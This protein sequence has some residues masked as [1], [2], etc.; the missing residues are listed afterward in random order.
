MSTLVIRRWHNAFAGFL[1]APMEINRIQSFATR[2]YLTCLVVLAYSARFGM[3]NTAP[4]WFE[5]LPELNWLPHETWIVRL[6]YTLT[7]LLLLAAAFVPRQSL[8]I[9][10]FFSWFMAVGASYGSG[11]INHLEASATIALGIMALGPTDMAWPIRFTGLYWILIIFLSGLNKLFLSGPL[12]PL[13]NPIFAIAQNSRFAISPYTSFLVKS[14]L[15]LSLSWFTFLM[16]LSFPAILLSRKAFSWLF[17]PM[18]GLLTAI[19][20]FLRHGFIISM[21]PLILAAYFSFG[22]NQIERAKEND[23]RGNHPVLPN[24]S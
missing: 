5:P 1:M 7:G 21:S 22:E 12:W 2:F 9:L 18:L 24:L 11:F 16:E 19:L 6:S 13:T 10:T 14:P 8:R 15:T 23:P 4:L 20:I 3:R 17:W